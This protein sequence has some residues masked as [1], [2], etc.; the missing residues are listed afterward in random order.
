M[1]ELYSLNTFVSQK[2]LEML[3]TESGDLP[4]LGRGYKDTII[5]ANP[6]RHRL[7]TYPQYQIVLSESH[8]FK[9]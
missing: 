9:V 5:I 3:T 2:P 8:F 6:V 7:F 4:S 1:G